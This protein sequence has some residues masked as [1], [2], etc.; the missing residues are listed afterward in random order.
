MQFGVA[1]FEKIV[2]HACPSDG[3][4]G[5]AGCAGSECFQPEVLDISGKLSYIIGPEVLG[6]GVERR[7]I[8]L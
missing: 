5:G 1:L 4:A 3:D 6:P 8:V 2:Y 7:L